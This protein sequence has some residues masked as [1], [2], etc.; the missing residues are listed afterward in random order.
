MYLQYEMGDQSFQR[1]IP[2]S[3]TKQT[4]VLPFAVTSLGDYT[5]DERYYTKRKG[6]KECLLLYSVEGEGIIEYDGQQ[7]I[8]FPGQI[9]VMDCRN[10]QYY[11]AN[12][13][14]WTFLWIHFNGKCAFDFVNILNEGGAAVINTNGRISFRNYFDKIVSCVAEFDL[15][16]ELE[17]SVIMQQ[18]LT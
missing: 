18:L 4:S 10:Y 6:V 1:T 9:M 16:K 5:C 17:I 13:K 8:L 7:T 2:L 11:A 14:K 12:G 3:E 15:K